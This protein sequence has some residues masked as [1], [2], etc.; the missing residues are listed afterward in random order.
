M[1]A[2][3]CDKEHPWRK[4]MEPDTEYDSCSETETE[5][6]TDSD[7]EDSVKTEHSTDK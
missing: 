6:E 2:L 5:T 3:D 1:H 4:R 7:N